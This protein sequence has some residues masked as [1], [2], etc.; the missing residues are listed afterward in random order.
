MDTNVAIVLGHT[1][2]AVVF[3]AS[4]IVGGIALVRDGAEMRS[5]RS[6]RDEDFDRGP[7]AA[8]QVVGAELPLPTI[9]SSVVWV[10]IYAVRFTGPSRAIFASNGWPLKGVITWQGGTAEIVAR[11]PWWHIVYMRAW[12]T[13]WVSAG[14][15]AAVYAIRD[16]SL[17]AWWVL[18][19]VSLGGLLGYGMYRFRLSRQTREADNAVRKLT[20][21]LRSRRAV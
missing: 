19:A 20:A 3:I 15:V 16:D 6:L 11:H 9:T 1:V 17:E 5:V 10:G 7:V 18:P 14:S 13:G 2:S 12:L 4:W 8:R 21:H